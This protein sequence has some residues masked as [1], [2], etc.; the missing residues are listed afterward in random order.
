MRKM[1]SWHGYGS[2]AR[3]FG[4][5][6]VIGEDCMPNSIAILVL[7]R[8]VRS[9]EPLIEEKY[10]APEKWYGRVEVRWVGNNMRLD[11]L[12]SHG[13]IRRCRPRWG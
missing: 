13:D 11:W 2:S 5:G 9:E 3:V 8:G 1:R 6:N 7:D 10:C 12:L 4:G